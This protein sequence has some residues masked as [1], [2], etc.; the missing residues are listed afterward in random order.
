VSA[1]PGGGVAA[2]IRRW[3]P[4]FASASA[5][6]VLAWRLA[7]QSATIPG[8]TVSWQEMH[9][10]VAS[11]IPAQRAGMAQQQASKTAARGDHRAAE[12]R[13]GMQAPFPDEKALPVRVRMRIAPAPAPRNSARVLPGF[14]A[15][16]R[17]GTMRGGR[18][19]ETMEKVKLGQQG[20]LCPMKE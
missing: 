4:G 17:R 11:L 13:A 7:F 8:V 6:V 9:S 20:F 15:L 14:P 5:G 1:V 3:I 19:G 18:R 12:N 16:A 10:S 2:E